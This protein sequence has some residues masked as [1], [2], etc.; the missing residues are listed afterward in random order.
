MKIQNTKKNKLIDLHLTSKIFVVE[1]KET[2]EE[3]YCERRLSLPPT[4]S[5]YWLNIIFSFNFNKEP[6]QRHLLLLL[7]EFMKRWHCIVIRQIHHSHCSKLIQLVFF[8]RLLHCLPH[9]IHLHNLIW[10][11]GFLH[12]FLLVQT[13]S[14]PYLAAE[15]WSPTI[16]EW[17]VERTT[18]SVIDHVMFSVTN[19]S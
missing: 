5:L 15:R 16:P 13:R 2:R 19:Y 11:K 8:F 9:F 7:L 3:R 1:V 4:K 17:W 14:H 12:L 10:S 6:I 18:G